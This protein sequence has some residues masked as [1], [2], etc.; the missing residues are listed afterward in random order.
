MEF[1]FI[2]YLFNMVYVNFFCELGK[3]YHSLTQDTLVSLMC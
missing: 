1:I 3:S 2:I